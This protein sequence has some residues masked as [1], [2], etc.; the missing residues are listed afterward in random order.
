M[1]NRT[2]KQTLLAFTARNLANAIERGEAK[3]FFGNQGISL[4]RNGTSG[5][6]TGYLVNAAGLT[7]RVVVDETDPNVVLALT[8]GLTVTQLPASLQQAVIDLTTTADDTKRSYARRVPRLV[9]Q[10]RALADQLDG[11]T[12]VNVPTP[13]VQAS[14]KTGFT[15]PGVPVR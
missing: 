4:Y 6:I 8:L 2:Q 14:T 11:Q 5:D 9:K 13:A 10:I 15:M 1:M 7:P 12:T 3:P